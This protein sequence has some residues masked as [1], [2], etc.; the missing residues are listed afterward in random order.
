MAAPESAAAA[1]YL[2]QGLSPQGRPS[3]LEGGVVPL[4]PPEHAQPPLLECGFLLS[5]TSP[6]LRHVVRRS[7]IVSEFYKSQ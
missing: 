3:G 2:G 7:Q 5:A 6:D 1:P 4:S